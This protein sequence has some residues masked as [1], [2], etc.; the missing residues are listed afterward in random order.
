MYNISRSLNIHDLP[1]LFE[2]GDKARKGEKRRAETAADCE[3]RVSVTACYLQTYREFSLHCFFVPPPR[4]C[5]KGGKE[6][7]VR[8]R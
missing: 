6:L 8:V 3:E 7:G 4:F 2:S 5:Y 1:T